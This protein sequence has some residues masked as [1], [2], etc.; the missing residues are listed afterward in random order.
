MS[1]HRMFNRGKYKK[2]P[3]L[4]FIEDHSLVSNLK[5]YRINSPTKAHFL[6]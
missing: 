3:T 4:I 1:N 6:L 2:Q 5:R